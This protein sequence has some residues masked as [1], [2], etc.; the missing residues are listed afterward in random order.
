MT[1]LV[2]MVACAAAGLAVAFLVIRLVLA[3]SGGASADLTIRDL[4]HTHK[5]PVPRMGGLGLVAAFVLVGGAAVAWHDQNL[6]PGQ[7]SVV[8]LALASAMFLL[9]FWD[10]LRPIGAKKKLLGQILIAAASYFLGFSIDK[11]KVPFVGSELVLGW[12]ALPLTVFWLVA[13]TNLINLV[14]GID[15]LAGGICL[16]LMILMVYVGLQTQQLVL[17]ASGMVG[18]LIGFLW[19]NFPPARIYMGTGEPTSLAFSWD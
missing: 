16:M 10:D 11:F 14:D 19:F 12:W 5:L 3:W 7:S 8:F 17:V 4:H 15:G 6:N 2:F 18:A 13:M 9:G 1:D